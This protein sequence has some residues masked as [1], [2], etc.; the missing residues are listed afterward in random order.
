[1][2]MLRAPQTP[3]T[4][5]ENDATARLCARGVSG[6][7]SPPRTVEAAFEKTAPLVD[8]AAIDLLPY[9]SE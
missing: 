8:R 7:T 3:P 6:V 2:T 1:M 5:S 4:S 9:L